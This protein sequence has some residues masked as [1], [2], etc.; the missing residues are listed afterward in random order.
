MTG[1]GRPDLNHGGMHAP[2]VI[3]VAD[4]SGCKTAVVRRIVDSLGP[5]QVTVV[6]HDRYYGHYPQLR[7]EER[8][9]L[10]HDHPRALV[11]ADAALRAQMDVK[12][13]VDADDD[14]RFIRR[15]KGPAS[16]RREAG[17][18]RARNPGA[19]VCRNRLANLLECA[20]ESRLSDPRG[21]FFERSLPR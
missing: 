15:L 11:L 21:E 3:G 17:A 6:E 1:P 20:A 16:R 9:A 8:A 2:L 14:T 19:H 13:F 18:R 7:L 4:G 10:N 5:D 12:V